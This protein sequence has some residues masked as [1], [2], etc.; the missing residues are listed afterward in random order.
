MKVV[1]FVLYLVNKDTV[2]PFLD[3]L[4]SAASGY[5]AWDPELVGRGRV[6]GRAGGGELTRWPRRM[7]TERC[8]HLWL[9]VWERR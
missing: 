9:T 5:R 2:V 8:L 3:K 6:S 1:I 4:G 7:C